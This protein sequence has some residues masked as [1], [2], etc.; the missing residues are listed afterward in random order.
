MR[1]EIIAI[2]LFVGCIV[3]TPRI[4]G[5]DAE[6][7]INGVVADFAD[8]I[9][10]S[11][12]L[13]IDAVAEIADESIANANTVEQAVNENTEAIKRIGQLLESASSDIDNLYRVATE[14]RAAFVAKRKLLE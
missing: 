8:E 7:I 10:A 11:I 13:D 4:S 6:E 1:K 2:A 5:Q 3:L 14:I 12:V 9:T